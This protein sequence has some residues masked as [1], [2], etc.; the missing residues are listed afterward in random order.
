MNT[1]EALNGVR[2]KLDRAGMHLQSLRESIATFLE[3]GAYGETARFYADEQ[4]TQEIGKPGGPPVVRTG[5]SFYVGFHFLERSTAPHEWGTVIGDCLHNM[6]SALDHL[7]YALA[8]SAARNARTEFPIFVDRDQFR[9]KQGRL[10]RGVADDA[11]TVIKWVQP[12]RWGARASIHPLWILHELN[13]IDKHRLLHVT[14]AAMFNPNMELFQVQN[15]NHRFTEV[16]RSGS[17]GHNDVFAK[18]GFDV[19]WLPEVPPATGKPVLIHMKSTGSTPK[20][21][22]FGPSGPAIDQEVVITLA[23]LLNG[24]RDR[25]VPSFYRFFP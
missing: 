19:P 1:P 23:G 8:G 6:R 2:L 22:V 5:T 12:Y 16:V 24:L 7:V 14:G 18:M 3:A 11:V 4:L 25:L 21:V 17:M 9:S 20:S 15:A 10:L 13:N